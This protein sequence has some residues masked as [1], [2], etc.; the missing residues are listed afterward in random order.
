MQVQVAFQTGGAI[1]TAKYAP[2]Q[3]KDYAT[4]KTLP[5]THQT[6]MMSNPELKI[7]KG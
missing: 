4:F 3:D 2:K 7:D 6:E 5:M 1:I